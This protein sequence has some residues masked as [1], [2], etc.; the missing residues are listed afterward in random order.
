[1]LRQ[2]GPCLD[3]SNV[4]LNRDFFL[5]WYEGFLKLMVQVYN[6]LLSDVIKEPDFFLSFHSAILSTLPFVFLLD[7]SWNENGCCSTR[8]P[9]TL[10]SGRREGGYQL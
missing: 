7:S 2:F 10:K 8:H 1:M 3:T 9:V 6:Q 4:T 5:L